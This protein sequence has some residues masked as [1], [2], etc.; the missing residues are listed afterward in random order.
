MHHNMRMKL[1]FLAVSAVAAATHFAYGEV[2]TGPLAG[3]DPVPVL[4]LNFPAGTKHD[5]AFA[6][7]QKRLI[8]VSEDGVVAVFDLGAYIG[9]ETKDIH[10]LGMLPST[11]IR[12]YLDPST[13]VGPL[14]SVA[15]SPD[16]KL[17]AV[18]GKCS[19]SNKEELVRLYDAA[20]L[21][22]RKT[23]HVSEPKPLRMIRWTPDGKHLVCVGGENIC[24]LSTETWTEEEGVAGVD[25]DI[26]AMATGEDQGHA[27]VYLAWTS[28][29]GRKHSYMATLTP[30]VFHPPE[31]HL[32]PCP[33]AAISV[34]SD[35]NR[36]AYALRNF[37]P[38][39]E[40]GQSKNGLLLCDAGLQEIARFDLDVYIS[41]DGL[42]F[43]PDGRYL[44]L[45]TLGTY[46]DGRGIPKILAVDGDK[47]SVAGVMSGD[48]PTNMVRWINRDT[49]ALGSS[50]NEIG[51]YRFSQVQ[52]DAGLR[53]TCLAKAVADGLAQLDTVD[54]G[55][56]GIRFRVDGPFDNEFR[57]GMYDLQE[58]FSFVTHR[59]SRLV[60]DQKTK[61]IGY[62]YEP[63]NHPNPNLDDEKSQFSIRIGM[64]ANGMPASRLLFYRGQSQPARPLFG[65]MDLGLKATSEEVYHDEINGSWGSLTM[66]GNFAYA[67]RGYSV[68]VIERGS[69]PMFAINPWDPD[70]DH[71]D[72]EGH[73]IDYFLTGV[74]PHPGNGAPS[75]NGRWYA[76]GGAHGEVVFWNLEHPSISVA[77]VRVDENGP[78]AAAGLK[79]KDVIVALDGRR[80]HT[81]AEF[82]AYWNSKEE[83]TISVERGS[84]VLDSMMKRGSGSPG[85]SAIVAPT[86]VAPSFHLLLGS[87]N[88]MH[89]GSRPW[90]IWTPH[91]YFDGSADALQSMGYV[92]SQ[93]PEAAANFVPVDRLS[94]RFFQ[95]GVIEKVVN[96]GYDDTAAAHEASVDADMAAAMNGIPQITVADHDPEAMQTKAARFE[97]PF[98]VHDNGGGVGTIAVKVNGKRIEPADWNGGDSPI[99]NA[100]RFKAVVP[101]IPGR[102]RISVSA[103]NRDGVFSAETAFEV[104]RLAPRELGNLY[105]IG[106]GLSNFKD[107][108]AEELGSNAINQTDDLASMFGSGNDYRH[109]G[110]VTRKMLVNDGASLSDLKAAFRDA[111][112]AMGPNDTF[113][114]IFSTHGGGDKNN[115]FEG[116][117]RVCLWDQDYGAEELARLMATVPAQKQLLILNACSAGLGMGQVVSIFNN[118]RRA[119]HSLNDA[120]VTVIAACSAYESSWNGLHGNSYFLD[121]LY[122]CMGGIL[123]RGDDSVSAFNLA[124]AVS[125]RQIVAR[126]GV[127][128][129]AFVGKGI[130]LEGFAMNPE[131][132]T[133]GLDFPLLFSSE[134]SQAVSQKYKEDFDFHQVAGAPVPEHRNPLLDERFPTD[135]IGAVKEHLLRVENS[136]PS[137]QSDTLKTAFGWIVDRTDARLSSDERLAAGLAMIRGKTPLEFVSDAFVQSNLRIRTRFKELTNKVDPLEKELADPQTTPERKGELRKELESINT[138]LAVHCWN[139]SSSMH[140]ELDAFLALY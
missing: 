57:T 80:F 56:D 113:I 90:I 69:V 89:G 9:S 53:V 27:V 112:A 38:T 96:Q 58:S 47:I 26:T 139:V 111:A 138:E 110:K 83:L 63:Q 62:A 13:N 131:Y 77:L 104:E 39:A 7:A 74:P 114:V 136:L 105:V 98:E 75:P 66:D 72:K 42:C 32:L 65:A 82:S 101:V 45:G 46:A 68:A 6:E 137:E 81:G 121:N 118:V 73:P 40:G 55:P 23:V 99:M 92:V 76:I 2:G 130:P 35:R 19:A 29:Y 8:T 4:N 86:I 25:G 117:F 125:K 93:S 3:P 30:G 87:G 10:E 11:L 67:C 115:G 109:F 88:R 106:I 5:L 17:I 85:F 34:S 140:R 15:V 129:Y 20:S 37:A 124:E 52:T 132:I 36:V 126:V 119:S 64:G 21:E 70:R 84:S 79:S 18:C 59:P 100:G 71:W 122:D 91:G 51:I 31:Q 43:S 133:S 94:A 134:L 127:Q 14:L 22:L 49:L 50:D 108:Y 61:Y 95:P 128:E 102:N 12:G 123:S 41:D 54:W 24:S 1:P 78:A 60:P 103:A 107:N 28:I 116:R 97:F 44:A 16:G 120:G 33:C 48:H 135:D